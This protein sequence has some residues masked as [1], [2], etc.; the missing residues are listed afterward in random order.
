MTKLTLGSGLPRKLN[1]ITEMMTKVRV[2]FY[3]VRVWT[4]AG[5]D[6]C[7]PDNRVLDALQDLVKAKPSAAPVMWHEI[8]TAVDA[9]GPDVVAAYE[10]LDDAGDGAVVYPDWK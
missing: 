4:I 9:L 7:G 8:S 3:T 5:D 10:V 1:R 6:D 2:G